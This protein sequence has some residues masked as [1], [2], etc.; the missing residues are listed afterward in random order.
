MSSK[1]LALWQMHVQATREATPRTTPVWVQWIA[2]ICHT[3]R[4]FV[5]ADP[6]MPAVAYRNR[7]A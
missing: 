2:T 3:L 5:E 4:R 7:R 1:T 6:V